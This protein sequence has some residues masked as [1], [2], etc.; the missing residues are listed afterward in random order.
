M[1]DGKLIFNDDIIYY[2]NSQIITNHTN[3]RPYMELIYS[4]TTLG[5][6][7]D[8]VEINLPHNLSYY[9][10]LC[11][12]YSV[13]G[14]YAST[15]E[16]DAIYTTSSLNTDTANGKPLCVFLQVVGTNTTNSVCTSFIMP[17]TNNYLC[18]VGTEDMR[19]YAYNE[20]VTSFPITDTNIL[21]LSRNKNS[22][23]SLSIAIYG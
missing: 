20:I 22:I 1:P 6:K 12:I 23:K 3:N 4:S 11:F 9:K 14:A 16:S 5:T 21:Y 17:Y 15:K 18:A 13:T 19:S 2:N 7:N 10:Q 8:Y